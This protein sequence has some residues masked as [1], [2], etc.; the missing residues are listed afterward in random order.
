MGR[1]VSRPYCIF[2]ICVAICEIANILKSRIEQLQ[3]S[4]TED[5]ELTLDKKCLSELLAFVKCLDKGYQLPA[6]IS[7]CYDLGYSNVNN[8]CMQISRYM[9]DYDALV[10]GEYQEYRP[11]LSD[12]NYAYRNAGI[13]E[14]EESKYQLTVDGFNAPF[15]LSQCMS[16]RNCAMRYHEMFDVAKIAQIC[17]D[18][19]DRNIRDDIDVSV[20]NDVESVIKAFGAIKE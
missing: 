12:Y 4:G 1:C 11:A 5:L 7:A 10:M 2:R 13:A 6:L 18:L 3:E 8:S 14:F 15:V 16:V 17:D 19:E 9:R 20:F